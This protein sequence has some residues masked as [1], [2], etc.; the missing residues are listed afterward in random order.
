MADY[1]QSGLDPKAR[2]I[3][4]W[5]IGVAFV[6]DAAY[7]LCALNW[8]GSAFESW[9]GEDFETVKWVWGLVASDA[10]LAA[11]PFVGVLD[12]TL[13]AAN[14]PRLVAGVWALCGLSGLVGVALSAKA[15][16]A[17]PSGDAGH[18]MLF[19]SSGDWLELTSTRLAALSLLLVAQVVCSALLLAAAQ[20]ELRGGQVVAAD[21]ASRA[22]SETTGA[23]IVLARFALALPLAYGACIGVWGA[24]ATVTVQG[25]DALYYLANAA[26]DLGPSAVFAAAALLLLCGSRK[27]V[28]WLVLLVCAAALAAFSLDYWWRY[29]SAAGLF[30]AASLYM[31]VLAAVQLILTRGGQLRPSDGRMGDDADGAVS[32]GRQL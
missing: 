29:E 10:V 21:D 19:D 14:R 23:P 6:I 25:Q 11:A 4:L 2:R 26:I 30:A 31:T 9:S 24:A 3:A 22:D 1:R 5:A 16:I 28:A 13:W 27:R 15:L 8:P 32:L 18:R 7:L 12:L 17:S 20:S